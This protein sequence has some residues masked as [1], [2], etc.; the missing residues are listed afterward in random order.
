[1]LKKINFLL[2]SLVVTVSYGQ[3]A[4]PYGS[5]HGKYVT[6]NGTKVYYEE[7]GKGTPL[8]LFEGGFGSIAQFSKCIPILSKKYHV[9]APDAPGQGRSQL[10]DSM[11]YQ[12][13]ADYMSKF[14]DALKLDSAYVIGWSDGGNTALILASQ[15][16]NKIKKVLVSGAN[17]KLEGIP[18]MVGDTTN[19][20]KLVN[21]PGFAKSNKEEIDRYVSLYPGRDWKKFIVDINKMWNQEIYFPASDLEAIHVPVMLVLGDHDIVS[22]EHGIEMHNLVKGSQFCVLPNTSH[23]VF[24]ERPELICEIAEDFFAD[25]SSS[26]GNGKNQSSAIQPETNTMKRVTGIGGIFFKCQDPEKMKQW[27][28]T[29]LGFDMDSYGAKFEWQPV[30]S[31]NKGYT[32]WSPFPDK[33]KYFEP[34]SGD[35]MINYTVDNLEALVDELKKEGVTVLDPIESS[36]YGKFVHILDVEGNKVELWEP[37]VE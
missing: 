26:S 22:L 30:G 23:G 33:T 35:F 25:K 29:H 19:Y 28:Q 2:F 31:A 1:M 9:I 10:A 20:E 12:L 14:V 32:L 34:S 8:L 21:S 36:E 7:Y 6:I 37:P 3:Q 4:I 17:Y 18:S 13:L 15:R 5:N 16:P 27:Y 24:Q 11:S